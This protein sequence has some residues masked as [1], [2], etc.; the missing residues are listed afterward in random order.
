MSKRLRSTLFIALP[1]MLLAAGCGSGSYNSSRGLSVTDSAAPS[2]GSTGKTSTTF[3]SGGSITG[4]KDAIVATPSIAGAMTVTVGAAQTLSVS[5][6]SSDGRVITG[7]GVSNTLGTLP[8]GWS[9]PASFTCAAVSTGSA[10]VLNLQYAPTA[11]ANGTLTID[12]VF[13]DDAAQPKT[14]GTLTIP[15]LATAANHVVATAGPSG[16]VDAVI[17]AGVQ[18]V[19][20]TFTPDDGNAITNLQ[21]TS[22]L[23]ALPPGWGSSSPAAA[24]AIVSTGSGCQLLLSYAPTAAGSGTVTLNYSYT[25]DMGGAHTGAVNIP[26]AA[27]TSDNVVGTASP[28]G[29]IVAVQ[30][31][32][33][34]PVAVTFTTDDGKPAGK[35]FLTSDLSKLP[36][37]WSAAGAF[38][39][40]TV[41]SG[42]GCQL[43]L[44]YAPTTLALGTLTLTYVYT[45]SGGA[46]RNG[47]LNVGYAGATNDVVIGT[48]SPSSQI[49]AIVS[50]GSQPG[51]GAQPVTVTFATGDSRPATALVL[52]TG[53]ASLP[54]G[55]SS[56]AGSF[57]C[58]A[59]DAD[60]TCVLTLSYAP[61]AAGA[62]ALP[63]AFTYT[64]NAG[65][66]K[67]GSVNIAYRATVNDNV[68]WTL[69]PTALP[70]LRTGDSVS[71]TVSFATDDGN[72]ASA[73]S[74]SGL[75]ILPAGWTAAANSLACA[76]VSSGAACTLTLTYA[77]TAAVTGGMLTLGYAYTNDAGFPATG[78]VSI[79]YSAYTPYLYVVDATTSSVSACAL[80]FN[81]SLS[82]CYATGTGFRGPYG[83]A[84]A[85]S[86]AY[87]TNTVGNSVTRCDLEANGALSGCDVTG[88]AFVAPTS[89]SI[90][91]VAG[92]AYIQQGSGRTVCPIATDGDL[93]ACSAVP[94]NPPLSESALAVRNATLYVVAQGAL[95]AC[96]AGT[97]ASLAGCKT[98]AAL[99]PLGLA[100]SGSTAY[101]SMTA[102]VFTCPV[103]VDG[104]L[105]ACIGIPD[106]TF[107]G[108]QGAAL[109]YR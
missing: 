24:C 100:F 25:D 65:E 62:G 52:T 80:S 6:T 35:L 95:L 50:D 3:E 44:T 19:S 75:D 31:A 51:N 76:T 104:T 27:T 59:L 82:A 43:H 70:S 26:Y 86:F 88:S 99:A 49:K 102:G 12:Y 103:G 101:L 92:L 79:P 36:A 89:I 40:A 66:Y 96:P 87:V 98:A 53:L 39:C 56:A 30:N 2:T 74:L 41:E 38:S 20:V 14:G 46:Q 45:D 67:T 78:T 57:Q 63:L 72:P 60:N 105:G 7:F 94:A 69:S 32:G 33:G 5:F 71:V 15:Y 22:N 97:A 107:S 28:T 18:P 93:G 48:E 17:G 58:A 23:T 108:T 55:W 13:V 42:N 73:L 47:L 37:G 64:N 68:G 21:V 4:T 81:D 77:P 83:I 61:T 90:D 1:L 29:Q 16:Q 84:L 106:A 9:G 109:R 85:G 10:C 54:P 34:Q 91:L 8:A 11:A